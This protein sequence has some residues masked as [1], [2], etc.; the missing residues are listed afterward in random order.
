[1]NFDVLIQY[2]KKS[3]LNK[4]VIGAAHQGVWRIGKQVRILYDLVTVFEEFMICCE[5]SAT[6]SGWEGYHER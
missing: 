3:Q 2:F 4:L 5:G 1:M 6:G